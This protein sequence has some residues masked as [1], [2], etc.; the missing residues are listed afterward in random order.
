MML[1]VGGAFHSPLMA[2]A[3][4]ELNAALDRADIRSPRVPVV[5]NVTAAPTRDPDE[6]R[7]R[8]KEQLTAPVL[9]QPTI[10]K[11]VASR[12]TEFVEVGP[13]KVLQGLVKRIATGAAT[14]GVDTVEDLESRTIS[15]VENS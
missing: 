12:V 5:L 15:R 11:L 7:A 6:I 10:E 8:L 14:W 4:Q 3:A 1:P 2:G 9:W 13:G